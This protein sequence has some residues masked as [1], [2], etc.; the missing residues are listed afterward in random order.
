M[1]LE[2]NY[3]VIL[4]SVVQITLCHISD[5]THF[6]GQVTVAVITFVRE[7]E[8]Q[9]KTNRI[10]EEKRGL[11]FEKRT[12]NFKFHFSQTQ[13]ARVAVFG[14]QSRWIAKQKYCGKLEMLA[15][16]ERKSKKKK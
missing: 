7:K 15:V 8:R 14:E 2:W 4:S 16:G 12:C 9:H 5:F 6:F 13:C 10:M 11:S 3:V 1:L